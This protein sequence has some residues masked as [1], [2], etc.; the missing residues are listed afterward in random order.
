MVTPPAQRRALI[1]FWD[2]Q[3]VGWFDKTQDA[4]GN[5]LRSTLRKKNWIR[6]I[7]PPKSFMLTKYELTDEG[8]EAMLS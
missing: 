1:W 6:K 7:K 2:H 4:P 3:P 8:R 5:R